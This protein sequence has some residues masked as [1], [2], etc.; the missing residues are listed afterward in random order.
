MTLKK[1]RQ[2]R[3]KSNKIYD[4]QY[5]HKLFLHAM[6]D[7]GTCQIIFF[8]AIAAIDNN[9]KCIFVNSTFNVDA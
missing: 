1:L 5:V 6:I 7:E 8:V 4:R 3:N 9:L 2:F